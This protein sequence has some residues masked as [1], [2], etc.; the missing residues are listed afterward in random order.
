MSR[1]ARQLVATLAILVGVLA[2]GTTAASAHAT[3]ESSSPADGQ[4]VLTSPSEI[5]ITF[6]ETV[7]TISGGLSVLKL[8]AV[9]HLLHQSVR[10]CPTARTSRRIGFFLPMVTL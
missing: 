9:G 10:H 2:L 7:T 6:S 1:I 4:S 8:S 5:R 3:L